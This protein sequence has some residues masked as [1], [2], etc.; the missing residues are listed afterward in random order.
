MRSAR[1]TRPSLKL[2]VASLTLV[3]SACSPS[4]GGHATPTAPTA[5]PTENVP[6]LSTA[7]VTYKGHGEAATGMA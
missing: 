7:L 1:T 2:L 5:T 3:A 6:V 4:G